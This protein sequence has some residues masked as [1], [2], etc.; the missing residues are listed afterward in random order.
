M[1]GKDE[2]GSPNKT[3]RCLHRRKKK[4]IFNLCTP[5]LSVNMQFALVQSLHL[6]VFNPE[7]ASI[8]IG[9]A[10]PR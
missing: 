1:N 9:G 7:F 2:F 10:I 5:Q 6:V 4:S 8:S 3:V